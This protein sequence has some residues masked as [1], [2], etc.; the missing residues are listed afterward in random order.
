MSQSSETLR[1]LNYPAPVIAPA[2]LLPKCTFAIPLR[3][4]EK[5][6]LIAANIF[7]SLC[8]LRRDFHFLCG[9]VQKPQKLISLEQN[10]SEEVFTFCSETI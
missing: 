1:C 10:S 9:S 2:L 3:A 7:L 5:E 6:F 8:S 4:S